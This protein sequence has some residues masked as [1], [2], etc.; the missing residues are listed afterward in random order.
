MKLPK[1][2]FSEDGE[3]AIVAEPM[4][5]VAPAAKPTTKVS[6]PIER[7]IVIREPFLQAQTKQQIEVKTLDEDEGPEYKWNGKK[8][9]KKASA[10]P[11]RDSTPSPLRRAKRD[12]VENRLRKKARL[13]KQKN[14]ATSIGVSDQRSSSI[15]LEVDQ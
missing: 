9:L 1:E 15:S 7:G 14:L 6:K 3:S 10:E 2:Y 5:N 12:A 11:S 13:H 8:K 4:N